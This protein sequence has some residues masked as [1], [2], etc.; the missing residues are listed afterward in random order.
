MDSCFGLVRPHQHGIVFGQPGT[1]ESPVHAP[2][3]A[4]AGSKHL[5][6]R[7]PHTRHVVAVVG[8]QVLGNACGCGSLRAIACDFNKTNKKIKNVKGS[9]K[10][11]Q[12]YSCHEEKL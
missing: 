2:F 7:Q 12:M 3:T 9:L 4:E 6:K 10:T 11:Q 8:S 5:F 1:L